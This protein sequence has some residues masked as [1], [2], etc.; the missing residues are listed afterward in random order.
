MSSPWI[1]RQLI[2]IFSRS[3]ADKLLNNI[4]QLNKENE[5]LNQELDRRANLRKENLSNHLEDQ[6]VDLHATFQDIE[7][8]LEKTL[9]P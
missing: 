5:R 7:E 4:N 9:S 2:N 1:L 6:L 3:E 8:Q